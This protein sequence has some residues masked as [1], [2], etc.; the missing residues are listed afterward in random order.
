MVARPEKPLPSGRH[1]HLHAKIGEFDICL[2]SDLHDIIE[3]FAAIYAGRHPREAAADQTIRMEVRKAGRSRLGRQLYR[4]YGDCEEIGGKHRSNEVFPF[5]EWG[6]NLRVMAR[7][8]EYLQ[9]HA[10]S[11]TRFGN[12][13]I[14]AGD[15]GCGKSTLAAG[16]LALGWGYLCDEFAL[17]KPST[18]C[19]HSFPKA[20][21]IKAGSFPVIRQLGLPFTRQ[22][23]YI[24][25]VKGRVSYINPR[26]VR[27]YKHADPAPI[28]YIIFPKYIKGGEPRLHRISRGRALVELTRSAFNRDAFGDR[29]VSILADVVH[30]SECFRLEI[31]DLQE[32][33]TLLESRL[34]RGP[35]V[36][37]SAVVPASSA[38]HPWPRGKTSPTKSAPSRREILRLGT[39]LAY[40]V[41]AVMTIPAHEAFAAGSAPSGAC[42]GGG[43]AAGDWCETDTDCCTSD[44]DLGICQ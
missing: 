31:G 21:C 11:M 29:A 25:G 7:R 44:C 10:A 17:I 37:R 9:L 28:Q 43:K 42:S 18:F 12:G 2:Q 32:T 19:L 40:V 24:K 1:R 5:L 26:D 41:P 15:S 3:D 8:T 27:N 34:G 23:D 20:L 14:F 30:R 38:P 22:R 35:L 4:V 36:S 13:F 16:L 6:I 39:K 33:C